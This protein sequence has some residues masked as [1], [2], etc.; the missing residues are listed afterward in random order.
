MID[1]RQAKRLLKRYSSSKN[2][3]DAVLRH[4]LAVRR[5]ALSLARKINH[6][7]KNPR[8]L[9]EHFISVASILHDI[10]RFKVPPGKNSIMHGFVGADILRKEGLDTRYVRVC[11]THMGAGIL[12][13][14]VRRLKLPVPVKDYLP[15]T[16]EEKVISYADSLIYH[17]KEVSFAS[18]CHRWREELGPR[19]ER[20]FIGLHDS[21]QRWLGSAPQRS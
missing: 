8:K 19:Y 2:D 13:S 4:S 12:A 11:Q 16:M 1:E 3:F 21:I 14:D 17:D 18:V 6:N 10:G 7:P 5:L 15:R 20:M 9:D